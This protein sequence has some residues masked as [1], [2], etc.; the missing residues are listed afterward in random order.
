MSSRYPLENPNLANGEATGVVYVSP[1]P[2]VLADFGP[3]TPGT[4]TGGLHEAVAYAVAQGTATGV[5]PVVE[6]LPGKFTFT[7]FSNTTIR[8]CVAIDAGYAVSAGPPVSVV[9][10]GTGMTM[11]SPEGTGYG[12]ANTIGS[13]V[14]DASQLDVLSQFSSGNYGP[15]RVFGVVPRVTSGTG[16]GS[17]HP[18]NA[19]DLTVENISFI[20]PVYN[21]AGS[22]GPAYTLAGVSGSARLFQNGDSQSSNSTH[23]LFVS[24]IDAW[25][26]SSFKF[27]NIRA[28]SALAVYNPNGNQYAGGGGVFAQGCATAIVMPEEAN[29]GNDHGECLATYD[30]PI[31]FT[32]STHT[33]ATSLYP[34]ASRAVM[35]HCSSGHGARIGRINPQNCSILI[36][37]QIL[38]Q[39]TN[40]LSQAL[41]CPY[42]DLYAQVG[43][44]YPTAAAPSVLIIEEASIEASMN[45]VLKDEP[46]GPLTVKMRADYTGTIPLTSWGSG[47]NLVV[48]L[49]DTDAHMKTVVTGT[50]AGTATWWQG[51]TNPMDKKAV[52]IL[53]GYQNSTA[54]PQTI[55]FRTPFNNAPAIMKD[56]SGGAT[57][58]TTTL[59]L[60]ASMGSAKT[61]WI[62]LEGY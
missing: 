42:G 37:H 1:D 56:D 10:R 55:T 25:S 9:I 57:V 47:V 8:A 44:T 50:T 61:G 2:N 22:Y 12:N 39:L 11:N 21:A 62:I 26:A 34:Q 28:A 20:L 3:Y 29:Q 15:G 46:T 18:L 24:A 4:V 32:P 27:R 58:S 41:Y 43:M 17:T 36:Q 19:V 40:S 30:L 60:P 33:D 53:A 35:Y 49:L 7:Q 23:W 14:I 31:A 52:V 48:D 38:P 45:F 51:G 5:A 59:T 13:T 16:F 54:T 6:L